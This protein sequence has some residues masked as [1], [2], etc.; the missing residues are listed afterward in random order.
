MT[1]VSMRVINK[2]E[3]AKKLDEL[4]SKAAKKAMQNTMSDVRSHIPGHVAKL[5]TRRYNIKQSDVRPAGGGTGSINAGH[6]FV[7]IRGSTLADM[8][9]V[10][11]GRR[12][13]PEP[14]QMHIGKVSK[15]GKYKITAKILKG[16]RKQIGHHGPPYSEGGAYGRGSNSPYFITKNSS[17]E[18]QRKLPFLRLAGDDAPS[19]VFRTVS[20]PQMVSKDP[21]VKPFVEDEL[22]RYAIERLTHHMQRYLG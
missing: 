16:S 13:T 12:L 19:E 14:F 15:K 6:S 4:A 7:G 5:V 2:P 21:E 17:G 3:L 20:I 11:K 1:G 9:L 8:V 18:N 10:Y 22:G